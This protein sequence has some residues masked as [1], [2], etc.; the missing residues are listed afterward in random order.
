[1]DRTG[2]YGSWFNFYICGLDL[3][4]QVLGGTTYLNS[5]SL[6]S[7]ERDTVCGGGDR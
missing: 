3:Q 7:N 4:L 2:S 6:S 1:M 5:P